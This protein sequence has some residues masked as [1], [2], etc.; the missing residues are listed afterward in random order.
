MSPVPDHMNHSEPLETHT[1]QL[2]SSREL[3][4]DGGGGNSKALHRGGGRHVP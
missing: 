3:G 1:A 4:V 2:L